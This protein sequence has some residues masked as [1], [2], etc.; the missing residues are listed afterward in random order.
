MFLITDIHQT[1]SSIHPHHVFICLHNT[2]TTHPNFM[3]HKYN[4]EISKMYLSLN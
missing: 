1:L 2:C 4:F 3:K